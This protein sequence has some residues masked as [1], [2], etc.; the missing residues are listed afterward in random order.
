MDSEI[1]IPRNNQLSKV[2]KMEIQPAHAIT[3]S[4]FH[5]SGFTDKIN[6]AST[7]VA[8]FEDSEMDSLDLSY[9][10][11]TDDSAERLNLKRK[12]EVSSIHNKEN[13]LPCKKPRKTIKKIKQQKEAKLV[14]SI[15][16]I[17]FEWF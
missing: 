12:R 1:E 11:N 4:G 8:D 17:V 15:L 9:I 14:S 16:E 2:D 10:K 7:P 13:T 3:D 6:R 5:Y